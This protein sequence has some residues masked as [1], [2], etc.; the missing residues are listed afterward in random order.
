MPPQGH[1]G[2][3]GQMGQMGGMMGGG[4]PVVLVNKLAESK[5]SMDI[6]DQIFVLFGV[7]GDVMR[8]KILFKKNDTA[9]IQF[10]TPQ[11][12]SLACAHLN[13][14]LLNGQ[15]IQVSPSKHP[16]V[17]HPR[18]G[19]E[20]QQAAAHLTRDFSQ[21]PLH[22][23][24]KT[25]HINLKNV[26]PPSQVLHVANLTDGVSTQELSS[27]FGSVQGS[28]AIVEFFKSGR[29]MAY[30]GLNSLP[31]AIKALTTLHNHVVGDYPIRVS[32]SKMDFHKIQMSEEGPQ[33][34]T[35]NA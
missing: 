28:P 17:F 31:D 8:I 27:L 14:C 10:R 18:E 21:S 30:V 15:E 24:A 1:H 6:M 4:G 11:Q 5:D 25:T 26:N 19:S 32:F 33:Q 13:G 12:A 9:L 34:V 22:R 3:M 23:Y 7:Y 16:E 35:Q 2:G 20:E 29:N